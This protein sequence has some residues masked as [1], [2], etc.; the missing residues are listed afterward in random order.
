MDGI[1][2]MVPQIWIIES[3]KNVQNDRQNHEL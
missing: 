2:D 3:L 1:K